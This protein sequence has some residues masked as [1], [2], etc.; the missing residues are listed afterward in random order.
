MVE[1]TYP[2][3]SRQQ[4]EKLSSNLIFCFLLQPLPAIRLKGRK[5]WVYYPGLEVPLIGNSDGTYA[6]L[7]STSRV[8]SFLCGIP[9]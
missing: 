7:A 2:E 6:I 5:G 1:Y 3:N 4:T 8:P 9:Y